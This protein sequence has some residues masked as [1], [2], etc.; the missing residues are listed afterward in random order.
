MNFFLINK[1]GRELNE[2]STHLLLGDHFWGGYRA[3]GQSQGEKCQTKAEAA[4]EVGIGSR[5]G[6]SLEIRLS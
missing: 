6:P 5:A 4:P 3:G 2:Q 1:K